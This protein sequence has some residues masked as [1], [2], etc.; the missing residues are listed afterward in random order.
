MKMGAVSTS[1]SSATEH[2]MVVWVTVASVGLATFRIGMTITVLVRSLLD[3]L[4][5][6]Q[7]RA[8]RALLWDWASSL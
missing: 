3:Y 5:D 2:S 1:V 6:S 7:H 4:S 8:V